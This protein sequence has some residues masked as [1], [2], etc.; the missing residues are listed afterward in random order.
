MDPL[1]LARGQLGSITTVHSFLFLP[2]TSGFSALVAG[3]GTTR[4]RTRGPHR[5]RPSRSVWTGWTGWTGCRTSS[6]HCGRGAIGPPGS[7]RR[8]LRTKDEPWV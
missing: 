4:V 6:T 5:L 3:Y 7:T 8:Q 2:T 1:E